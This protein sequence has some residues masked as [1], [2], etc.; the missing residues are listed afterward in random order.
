MFWKHAWASAHCGPGAHG[1][2]HSSHEHHDDH[3]HSRGGWSAFG[4]RRPLRFMAR[5][6][7]LSEEQVEKLAA[8]LD[9]LKTQRAQAKVDRHK[10]IGVFA[11]AFLGDD[12]DRARVEEACRARVESDRL[13]EEAVARA[14]ERTFE[15]LTKEQRKR[16]A[17]LLRSES[18]TI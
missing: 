6:L 17:Y 12:F 7:D 5:Q 3:S 13:V 8:I 9:D 1:P 10:T 14:L 16:L 2:H 18:L 15:V 11:D 4:V